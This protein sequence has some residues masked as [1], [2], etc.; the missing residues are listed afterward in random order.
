MY[1]S[2][3]VHITLGVLE[4]PLVEQFLNCHVKIVLKVH[5]IWPVFFFFMSTF[6]DQEAGVD[7]QPVAI[8]LRRLQSQR[9]RQL[10]LQEGKRHALLQ[11]VRRGGEAWRQST[12]TAE[13]TRVENK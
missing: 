7:E 3:V 2:F 10:I 4:L 6:I 11:V 8:L 13:T 1:S 12:G 9:R 5:Q